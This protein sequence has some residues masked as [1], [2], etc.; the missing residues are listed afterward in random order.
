M[1]QLKWHCKPSQHAADRMALDYPVSVVGG[2]VAV[3]NHH[4]LQ[5]EA[6][7][8]LDALQWAAEGG[9]GGVGGMA[10]WVGSESEAPLVK[11]GRAESL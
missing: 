10:D 4:G 8:L 5:M 11:F 7:A 6:L 2:T 3:E 1:T 9:E